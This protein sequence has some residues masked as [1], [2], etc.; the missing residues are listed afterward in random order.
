MFYS[1]PSFLNLK[2]NNKIIIEYDIEQKVFS[3]FQKVK[4]MN[5]LLRLLL[6]D[7]IFDINTKSNR[8]N[9]IW[10]KKSILFIGLTT[11]E[12]YEINKNNSIQTI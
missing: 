11:T 6:S 7:F 3:Q 10:I 4:Q 12:A 1:F 5:E 2:I 8:I 9:R